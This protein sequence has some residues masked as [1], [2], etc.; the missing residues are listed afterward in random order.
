MKYKDATGKTIIESFKQFHKD[1]PIVY[2]LFKRY[3]MNL[4]HVGKKKL[5]S[6]L[7][8][9]RIR[10]EVYLETK[11]DEL[12]RINDAFTAHYAR[13]FI[14]DFPQHEDKFEF[15]RLRADEPTV[16][17]SGQLKLNL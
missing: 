7:I 6:K 15:R 13:L 1:N 10:W 3:A 8:I 11:T 2:E 9:N 14:E 12:Y 16:E 5:S 17:P 4:I